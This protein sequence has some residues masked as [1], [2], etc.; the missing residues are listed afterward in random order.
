MTNNTKLNNATDIKTD[1]QRERERESKNS[2]EIRLLMM[3]KK[4]L[5]R[6]K[7]E[8]NQSQGNWIT[9]LVLLT[10]LEIIIAY[11]IFN[12]DNGELQKEGML[13]SILGYMLFLIPLLLLIYWFYRLLSKENKKEKQIKYK[14]AMKNKQIKEYNFKK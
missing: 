5:E 4:E 7:Q 10:M 2:Q 8:I 9:C 3:E 6:K 13:A 14:I 11:Q 1:R 12:S